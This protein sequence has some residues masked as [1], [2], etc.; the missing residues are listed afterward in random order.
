MADPA[1]RNVRCGMTVRAPPQ[2]RRIRTYPGPP[3]P[4][5][6]VLIVRAPR[7]AGRSPTGP[8]RRKRR[9]VMA[10]L[11]PHCRRRGMTVRAPSRGRRIRTYPG[12]PRPGRRV[13]IVRA[14]RRAGRSPTGPA[15][16]KRRRVMADP[17]PRSVRCGMTVRAPSYRR[18]M[19]TYPGPPWPGRR[20]ITV[21]APVPCLAPPRPCRP[22]DAGCIRASCPASLP[23]PTPGSPRQPPSPP[24][25]LAPGAGAGGGHC[26]P[27]DH[28]AAPPLKCMLP[29]KFR[30][31]RGLAPPRGRATP[32]PTPPAPRRHIPPPKTYPC[33]HPLLLAGED[34]DKGRY[35]L[36][37]GTHALCAQSRPWT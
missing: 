15:R 22:A 30:P 17:A 37:E 26:P 10:D 27:T 16:R 33:Q 14:P 9:R 29:S 31:A 3:R 7:R 4:G 24:L 20:V 36:L 2:R 25:E 5:R 28:P 19:M 1:P 32:T 11:P 6:R 13:L 34:P 12:P 35:W 18:R 8:A 23:L 21:R